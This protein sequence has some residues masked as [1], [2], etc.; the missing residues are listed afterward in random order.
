VNW[1]EEAEG[2]RQAEPRCDV[3]GE[4]GVSAAKVLN[5]RM[6]GSIRTAER[7]V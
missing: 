1:Q 6:A 3:G 7:I 4:F 2:C 5:E